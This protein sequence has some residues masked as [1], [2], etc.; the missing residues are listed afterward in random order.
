MSD[1]MMSQVI[2]EKI[3]RRY[4]GMYVRIFDNQENIAINYVR[5]HFLGMNMYDILEIIE[6][7]TLEDIY[8]AWNSL[9]LSNRCLTE[10]ISKND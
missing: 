1:K 4:Y 2:I 7:I 3:K 9:D 6:S 5:N 10:I 8:N